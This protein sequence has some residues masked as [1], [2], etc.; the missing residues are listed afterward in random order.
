M[1]MCG[2]IGD[3]FLFPSISDSDDFAFI[4]IKIHQPVRFPCLQFVYVFLQCL[5]VMCKCWCC[6]IWDSRQQRVVRLRKLGLV[7][8]LCSVGRGWGQVQIPMGRLRSLG[9]VK[10][11][12]LPG[13]LPV[14]DCSESY[15]PIPASSLS[16]SSDGVW[17]PDGGGALYQTPLRSPTPQ[18]RSGH[19]HWGIQIC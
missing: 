15:S 12:S 9:P 14:C 4:R 18:R 7:D 3:N 8:R 6:D 1:F 10:T 5:C 17:S 16:Y 11:F 19:P 13:S 2:V